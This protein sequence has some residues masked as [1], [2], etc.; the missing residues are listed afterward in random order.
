[1]E[2]AAAAAEGSQ[3]SPRPAWFQVTCPSCTAALQVELAAGV[4]RVECSSCKHVFKVQVAER[5]LPERQP[6]RRRHHSAHENR[7]RTLP[8]ILQVYNAF[9]KAETARLKRAHPAIDRDELL[10]TVRDNWKLAPENPQNGG[11]LD[12]GAAAPAAPDRLAAQLTE[13]AE[14]ANSPGH[15]RGRGHGHGALGRGRGRATGRGLGGAAGRGPPPFGGSSP[16]GAVSREKTRKTS[17]IIKETCAP[18]P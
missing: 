4:T 2:A 12:G 9:Q 16:F 17:S 13:E 3:A 11:R 10:Q 1:M 15:G 7:A 18:E 8:A 14:V 6:P 5:D